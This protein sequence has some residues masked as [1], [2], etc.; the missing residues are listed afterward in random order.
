MNSAIVFGSNAALAVVCAMVAL[1]YGRWVLTLWLEHPKT[2]P[3]DR[4]YWAT[5][6]AG[7]FLFTG[8]DAGWWTAARLFDHDILDPILGVN[9][10]L[11]WFRRNQH[12]LLLLRFGA[13]GLGILALHAYRRIA[14]HRSQT[15]AITAMTILIFL[16]STFVFHYLDHTP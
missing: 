5:V 1:I 15:R 2:S 12:F 14:Y 16:V 6:M 10:D 9:L 3:H 4:I 8:I 11:A 13:I 7:I